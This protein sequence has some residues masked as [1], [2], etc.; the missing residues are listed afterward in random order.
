MEY[1]FQNEKISQN[2]RVIGVKS[3]LCTPP[4]GKFL[5]I[6]FFGNEE[7]WSYLNLKLWG[8]P[9]WKDRLASLGWI[10][11]S[12]FIQGY[13]IFLLNKLYP[14]HLPVFTNHVAW[15]LRQFKDILL[16]SWVKSYYNYISH[17]MCSLLLLFRRYCPLYNA[18][19]CIYLQ[20]GSKISAF[21]SWANRCSW[22]RDIWWLRTASTP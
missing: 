16:K 12:N 11:I 19:L 9:I 17:K 4:L 15:E 21:S 22:C 1:Y 7:I 8:S 5:G 6:E 10:G 14:T 13:E 3:I 18:I 2:I 20:L